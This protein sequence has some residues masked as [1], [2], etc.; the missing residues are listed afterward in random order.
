MHF[1][2]QTCRLLLRCSLG[3]DDVVIEHS[4][5]LLS[6]NTKIV[7]QV[8]ETFLLDLEFLRNDNVPTE[9]D[10]NIAEHPLC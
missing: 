7:I 10:A 2:V 1:I 5:N 3:H 9:V 8:I 4:A 6:L